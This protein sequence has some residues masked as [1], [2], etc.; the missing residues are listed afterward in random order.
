MWTLTPKANGPIGAGSHENQKPA[1]F[2]A[3]TTKHAK[4][5]FLNETQQKIALRKKFESPRRLEAQS[6]R[7]IVVN[8]ASE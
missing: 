6:M 3:A 8:K 5:I 7:S 2:R 1:I 4:S